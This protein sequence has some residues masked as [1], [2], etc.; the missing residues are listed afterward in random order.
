MPTYDYFPFD[1]G[2]GANSMESRWRAMFQKMKTDG[3]MVEGA[4]MD[5]SANN[6]AVSAGSGMA[7][8]I[9]AGKAFVKGHCF[10]HSGTDAT[11]AIN[12]NTSGSTRTDLVVLRC[13]F[14][15]NTMQYQV[16][17]GTTTPVQNANNWD[18]PLATVAVPNNASSASSFTITD[19]RV[20][21]TPNNAVIPSIKRFM[22]GTMTLATATNTLV[23]YA[24]GFNWMT[25]PSMYPGTD[26]TRIV[27]PQDGFYFIKAR[28]AM[29]GASGAPSATAPRRTVFVRKNGVDTVAINTVYGGAGAMDFSAI[30]IDQFLAGDY[31]QVLV[32]HDC[33]TGITVQ[34]NTSEFT[35]HYMGQISV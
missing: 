25:M 24:G 19:K 31:L 4:S 35:V 29:G 2:L 7:V 22:S 15:N 6:M 1:S 13:D 11:L 34:V 32:F 9:V 30:S 21:A 23:S 10:I 16:L 8:T 18:L 26:N 14:V 5:I 33:G 3:I 17:Q 12:S 28:A 20:L 27:I